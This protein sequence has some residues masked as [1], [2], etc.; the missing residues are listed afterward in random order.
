MQ[1]LR[2]SF[3]RFGNYADLETLVTIDQRNG[4]YHI[5]FMQDPKAKGPLIVANEFETLATIM[6]KRAV[7]INQNQKPMSLLSKL[8]MHFLSKTKDES[9]IKAEQ[10]VFYYH[11]RPHDFEWEE[12]SRV[13]MEYDSKAQTFINP[14]FKR[15]D[16]I[17][18]YIQN[19]HKKDKTK[20]QALEIV[21]PDKLTY[22]TG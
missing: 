15:Y 11:E 14:R 16:V 12:F 21:P 1:Q 20:L 13:D 7:E 17:P 18:E 8:R 22:K 3:P 6:Y 4:E 2:P 10:F 9:E 19:V 5:C